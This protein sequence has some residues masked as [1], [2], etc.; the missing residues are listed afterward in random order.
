MTVIVVVIIYE[1]VDD[2]E[3]SSGF[4]IDRSRHPWSN[5][6]LFWP[7]DIPLSGTRTGF[8]V[9][10]INVGEQQVSRWRN[11]IDLVMGMMTPRRSFDY[12][13]FLVGD[14]AIEY[15]SII[16]LTRLGEFPF[17]GSGH[18]SSFL[19]ASEIDVGV[20]R[21]RCVDHRDGRGGSAGYRIG[22]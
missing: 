7:F 20:C 17:L 8:V 11:S 22:P 9:F 3:L 6:G 4:D 5:A 15:C 14:H 16:L 13:L 18:G 1:S 12:P 2:V 21:K 10:V 19:W